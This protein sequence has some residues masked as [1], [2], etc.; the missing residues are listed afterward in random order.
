MG[1][2]RSTARSCAASTATRSA[3]RTHGRTRPDA[4][5]AFRADL[6][7]LLR[8]QPVVLG[9]RLLVFEF[10]LLAELVARFRSALPAFAAEQGARLVGPAPVDGRSVEPHAAAAAVLTKLIDATPPAD[11]AGWEPAYGRL[12]EAQVKWEAAHGRPLAAK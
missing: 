9:D 8:R 5:E 2:I 11:L 4:A 7:K 3:E 6:L 10:R 1:T 12:A